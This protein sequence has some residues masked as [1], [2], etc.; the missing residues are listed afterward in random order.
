MQQP[1][2][3]PTRFFNHNAAMSAISIPCPACRA[4]LKLPN[5]SFIGKTGKCPKC[6]HRFVLALPKADADEVPLML[7]D[8]PVLP[9]APQKGTSARWVPDEVPAPAIPNP[10][11]PSAVPPSAFDFAAATPA[12]AVPQTAALPG[13]DTPAGFA[14]PLNT[15]DVSA[16]TIASGKRRGVARK[17]TR[18]RTGYIAM[19]VTAVV[20]AGG[21]F[22]AFKLINSGEPTQVRQAPAVNEKWE[23]QKVE[24]AA[25]N[26]SAE[27]LSPTSGEPIPLDYIPFT[28]HVLCHLRP[29]ELW[30]KDRSMREF[31]AML[32]DLGLWLKDQIT[33]RTRFEPEDIAELTFAINFGPRMSVPEVAVVVRLREA[34]SV[35]DLMKR[36]RGR[37]RPDPAVEVYEADDF[38]FLLID[39]QTFAV[40]PLP[41]AEDLALS[42]N[43]P[44]LAAPDMEPLIRESD[45]DRHL[46]ILFDRQL[47]DSHREDIFLPQMQQVADKFVLWL[48][49]EIE[50]VSWSLHAEPNLYMETLLNHGSTSSVL[51]VQRHAQL[52]FSRLPETI[53]TAVRMMKPATAGSRQMIGRFPAMLQALNLGT[54]AHAA[55][56]CARL[57][58]ILPQKAAANLAAGALLTWNQSLTTNFDDDTRLT[59]TDEVAVPDKIVDRLKMPVIID[60]RQTPLQEAFQFIADSIKT[61]ASIDGDGL[62]AAGFTQ[63]MPQTFDLGSVSAQAALHAIIQKY[64]AERDPLVLIVDEAGKKLMLSTK[65][66]AEAD[67]LTPFDTSPK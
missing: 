61:E 47:L 21:A 13:A 18:S 29:A 36:F 30:K 17:R 66:K 14:L 5:A 12:G 31:Q 27:R 46:T 59:K 24:I 50:T 40:A 63:N 22:A 2:V 43:D 9:L 19:L 1:V 3:V 57:V 64:A 33:T 26:E 32:G 25:S 34:H 52:Q 62:K 28:P 67:G 39:K 53:L 16:A 20:V 44:A 11:V 35:S 6:S 15:G 7:A 23:E 45:R 56:T 41:L 4:V 49:E 65:S 37:L 51:K 48:G 60:F 8:V 38:A 55:P 58:T 42:K 10:A 54:S